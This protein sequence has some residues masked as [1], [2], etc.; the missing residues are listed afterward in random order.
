M[1]RMTGLAEGAFVVEGDTEWFRIEDYDHLDPFLMTVVSSG[2]QWMYV[3]SSG[4]LAAG[5]ESAEHSLF[6]YETDDRLHRA[7][8]L[9]GPITVIRTNG[10]LWEPFAARTPLGVVQR[11]LA[12]SVAGDRLRFSECNP[13]LGLTFTYTW[14][15]AGDFG[16]IRSC[17]LTVDADHAPT[18]VE[19]LRSPSPILSEAAVKAM[20]ESR[21][22]PGRQN[23]EAVKVQL[24]LPI[25]FALPG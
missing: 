22:E 17:E 5:R 13:E 24:Q 16:V 21:F 20:Q 3:S 7:A 12:K 15:T 19:V 14:T 11:S 2:D 18:R 10:Q 1:A 9:T 6:P 8:G 23:G 25:R 4:A